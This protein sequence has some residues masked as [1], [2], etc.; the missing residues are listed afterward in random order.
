MSS[1]YSVF[2][3]YPALARLSAAVRY[4]LSRFH[5]KAVMVELRLIRRPSNPPVR[6]LPADIGSDDRE[7]VAASSSHASAARLRTAGI[8][9]AERPC[10]GGKST[11]RKSKARFGGW[12]VRCFSS[13]RSS[14]AS[15]KTRMGM[16]RPRLRKVAS[17]P[18][19]SSRPRR[20]RSPRLNGL[21]AAG[22]IDVR[23]RP[24]IRR[25]PYLRLGWRD[26]GR[27]RAACC[28]SLNSGARYSI[29]PRKT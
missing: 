27:S 16:A 5:L 20:P 1:V 2:W 19:N 6:S 21:D 29:F 14:C 4:R 7:A 15:A 28:G 3:R 25:P 17:S 11:A 22:C 8:L 26:N 10:D 9:A 23:P 12:D 24:L 13:F 18:R